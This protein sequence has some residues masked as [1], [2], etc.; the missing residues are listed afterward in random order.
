M[1]Q[2]L[3]SDPGVLNV[4]V[5]LLIN[6]IESAAQGTRRARERGYNRPES[7]PQEMVVGSGKEQRH[8]KPEAGQAITVAVRNA[9]YQAVQP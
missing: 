5:N 8:A 4:R 3:G 9:F 6:P 1:R 7:R 2:V